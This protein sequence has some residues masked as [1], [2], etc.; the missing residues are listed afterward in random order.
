MDPFTNTRYSRGR[1]AEAGNSIDLTTNKMIHSKINSYSSIC[2]DLL[3]KI[4]CELYSLLAPN[5]GIAWKIIGGSDAEV[6]EFPWMVSP[7]T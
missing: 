5:T 3:G 2:F 6:G 1:K 7:Y 4:A